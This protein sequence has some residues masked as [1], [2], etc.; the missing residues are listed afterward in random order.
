M[1]TATEFTES[2]NSPPES[3][4][5]PA[6]ISEALHGPPA[7]TRTRHIR[8]DLTDAQRIAINRLRF[9]EGITCSTCGVLL[10]TRPESYAKSRTIGSEADRLA[11]VCAECRWEAQEAARTQAIRAEVGRQNIAKA[12]AARAEN[13]AAKRERVL[14]QVATESLLDEAQNSAPLQIGFSAS[15]QSLSRRRKGGRPRVP[16]AI[17]RLRRRESQRTRRAQVVLA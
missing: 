11:Y 13:R 14:S 7:L 5:A 8:A 2:G 9:P 6:A 16:E 4:S 15:A 3:E 12:R 1:T 10:A 17:Q